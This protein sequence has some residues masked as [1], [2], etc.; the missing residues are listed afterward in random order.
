MNKVKKMFTVW[1]I[2]CNKGQLVLWQQPLFLLIFASA[3]I[4]PMRVIAVKWAVWFLRIQHMMQKAK[5]TVNI[6]FIWPSQHGL[7]SRVCG[8]VSNRL[9]V[10][11]PCCIYFLASGYSTNTFHVFV[12][13]DR[14]LTSKVPWVS[15]PIFRCNILLPYHALQDICYI[16]P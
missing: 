3:K 1:K 10:V 9:L 14:L 11:C 7:L 8:C 16:S 5:V 4:N 2:K 6:W 12:R 13:H 15:K